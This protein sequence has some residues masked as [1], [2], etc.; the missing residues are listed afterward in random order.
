MLSHI[1]LSAMLSVNVFSFVRLSAL[2]QSV[3]MLSGL[4]VNALM[5]S[6]ITLNAA[7]QNLI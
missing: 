7:T 4:K 6:V 2:R 3:V 5:L 1:M